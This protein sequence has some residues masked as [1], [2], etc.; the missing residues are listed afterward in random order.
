[1]KIIGLRGQTKYKDPCDLTFLPFKTT[2]FHMYFCPSSKNQGSGCR[3]RFRHDF[4][5][6][7]PQFAIWQ[8]LLPDTT[9]WRLQE[10][11]VP[12]LLRTSVVTSI[13]QLCSKQ[14]N[15]STRWGPPYELHNVIGQFD[16]SGISNQREK[17]IFVSHG[18]NFY[19]FNLL[20]INLW[21]QSLSIINTHLHLF[22]VS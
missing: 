22:R 6:F 18:Y 21:M 10:Q 1:M 8:S 5:K 11:A 7:Q 4:M 9:W 14:K 16:Y 13:W 3:F 20:E 17:V 12:A 19:Q 15:Y 2:S